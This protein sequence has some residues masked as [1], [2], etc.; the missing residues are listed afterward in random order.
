MAT[1]MRS[2]QPPIQNAS[3]AHML[4]HRLP[5]HRLMPEVKPAMRP[6]QRKTRH[7]L[8]A[9][10]M[11]AGTSKGL[12]IHRHDLPPRQEEWG[13]VLL[14]AMGSQDSDPLQLNGVGG[15]TSTTSK[16]S[17]VAP[18]QRPDAH[19]DYTFVQVSVGSSKI[20]MT[21]NCGN[22]AAGVGPFAV[23][24]GLVKIEQGQRQVDVRIFN[25]NTQR[26]LVETIEVD[27]HGRCVED[28]DFGIP[29]V[30]STGSCIKM[31][32]ED[33]EGAMTGRLLPSGSPTDTVEVRTET[34]AGPTRVRVSAIDAA[35]PFVF[36]DRS[37]IPRSLEELGPAHPDYL[38]F[39]EE[40]RRQGAVL[41]GLAQTTEQA[42]KIRGTPKVAVVSL[43]S[44]PG[45]SGMPVVADVEVQSFSMG[46]PHSSL[47]MTGAVPLAAA[48]CIKGTIIQDIVAQ[49]KALRDAASSSKS[50]AEPGESF[51]TLTIQHP[52]GLMPVEVHM[53]NESKISKVVLSRT[54][55]RLFCGEVAYLA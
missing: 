27:E 29:G 7:Y 44:T 10:W 17:V 35:N 47:Q 20:D 34:L 12:F 38:S 46:K 22:M 3:L 36:V 48:A 55:R 2:V 14:S 23:D 37:D 15:A 30:L 5:P 31:S 32:F 13:P 16:I 39:V 28:G 53:G 26:M 33:P 25:T 49:T 43:P 1:T 19:V 24:E 42:A 51:R 45:T 4:G 11:R 9:V 6:V 8:P 50:E 40:V 54:A 41:M 18:S 52:K 21:G